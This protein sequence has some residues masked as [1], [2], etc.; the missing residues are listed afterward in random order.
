MPYYDYNDNTDN[1]CT[2]EELQKMLEKYRKKQNKKES[3]K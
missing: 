3:P 1:S 2:T